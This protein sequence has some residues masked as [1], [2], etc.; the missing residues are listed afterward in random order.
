MKILVV[1]DM[2]KDFIDGSLGTPEA[3]AILDKVVDRVAN[4]QGEL[5][6]F[7]QDTHQSDYLQTS[8]GK[9]LPVPHCIEGEEGWQ[10]N[11]DILAAWRE[12]SNTMRIRLDDIRDNTFTKPVFGST[13]LVEYI[14]NRGD[15][16]EIELL[17][18]CTDICV[19]SNAIMLKNHLPDVKI[20]VNAAC[21]AGVTPATHQAALDVMR[22]CQ[23]D[24]V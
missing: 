6:L 4:S 21:C 12:N 5:V 16:E 10:I 9:K 15:V 3:V 19:V 17:G 14:V 18:L 22:M 2:Q 1:I 8:E 11:A 7:T 23:I 24:I 13:A 20:S